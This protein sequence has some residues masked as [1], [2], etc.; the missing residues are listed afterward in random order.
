MLT[1]F[2]HH[3]PHWNTLLTL[4]E[5]F[6]TTQQPARPYC[7]PLLLQDKSGDESM[8]ASNCEVLYSRLSSFL[9]LFSF[10]I[11]L[12]ALLFFSLFLVLFSL[13]SLLC[14]YLLS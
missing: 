6:N 14:L 4:F 10:L 5:R 2:N 3:K 9:S 8:L 7:A 13:F 1:P 12:L 11:S